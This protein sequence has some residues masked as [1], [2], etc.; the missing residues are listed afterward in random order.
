MLYTQINTPRFS[1]EQN[2]PPPTLRLSCR[3]KYMNIHRRIQVA[4]DSSSVLAR[5]LVARIDVPHLPV[6]PVQV[7]A[8]QRHRVRMLERA[9]D[10]VPAVAAVQPA[11]VNVLQLPVGP[12]NALGIVVDRQPVRPRDFGRDEDLACVGRPVH[13]RPFDLGGLAPVGPVNVTVN[14][15]AN[16]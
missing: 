13:S 16:M 4:D 1:P 2:E 5:A 8:E 11:A 12:V 6:S 9:V 10:D 14:S 15:K 7:V 3:I